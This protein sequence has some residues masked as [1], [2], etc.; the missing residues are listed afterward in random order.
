MSG[1]KDPSVA[2]AWPARQTMT[3]RDKVNEVLRRYDIG[4]YTLLQMQWHLVFVVDEPEQVDALLACLPSDVAESW[5]TWA[6]TRRGQVADYAG[7]HGQR[8]SAQ[9]ARSFEALR[10]WLRRNP[11]PSGRS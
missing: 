5:L 4:Y 8:M 11:P 3:L 7:L 9:E 1:R 6:R 2:A 10:A